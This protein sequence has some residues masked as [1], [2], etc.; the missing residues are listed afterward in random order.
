MTFGPALVG[1]SLADCF[2]A[3]KRVAPDRE[4]ASR[5]DNALTRT[6]CGGRQGCRRVA[7]RLLARHVDDYRR[8]LFVYPR[9]RFLRLF[10]VFLA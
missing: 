7:E 5:E 9:T 2:L 10:S 1:D 6:F 8:L 4:V 3:L